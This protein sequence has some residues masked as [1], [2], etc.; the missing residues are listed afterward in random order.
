MKKTLIHPSTS[1]TFTERPVA[2]VLTPTFPDC[3]SIE[4]QEAPLLISYSTK[5][6]KQINAQPRYLRVT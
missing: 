4:L 2:V 5:H 3:P 6:S 1:H